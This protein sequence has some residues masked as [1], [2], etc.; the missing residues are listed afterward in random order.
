MVSVD[1]G[2]NIKELKELTATNEN[3]Y[4]D[5]IDVHCTKG[6]SV[7]KIVCEYYSGSFKISR[8]GGLFKY[9]DAVEGVHEG[10][11]QNMEWWPWQYV[12]I[13][14]PVWF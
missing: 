6:R 5:N 14:F 7:I 1:P 11:H 9:D 10:M 12:W 8:Q 3:G 4:N 13:E 2:L